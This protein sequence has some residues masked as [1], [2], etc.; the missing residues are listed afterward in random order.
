MKIYTKTGDLGDSGLPDGNRKRKSELVFHALG[1]LDE[2]NAALGVCRIF[3]KNEKMGRRARE[4]LDELLKGI[5]SDL[6]KLGAMVAAARGGDSLKPEVVIDW[7]DVTRLEDT[8][9]QLEKHLPVLQNFI[10]PGGSKTGA[11]LHLCRAICRRLERSLIGL[12]NTSKTKNAV[13]AYVNRLSD[14]FFVLARY[15]NALLKNEEEIWP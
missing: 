3:L 8:I 9:D 13:F 5:Q 15:I 11:Q 2:V 14:L 1:D 7:S 4:M 6:L 10:I 12:H